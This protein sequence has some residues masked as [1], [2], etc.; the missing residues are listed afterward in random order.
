MNRSARYALTL[1][2]SASLVVAGLMPAHAVVM[3]EGNETSTP[4]PE[5]PA[6]DAG[7]PD[8]SPVEDATMAEVPVDG[9]DDAALDTLDLPVHEAHVDDHG[10]DAAPGSAPHHDDMTEGSEAE[11]GDTEGHG[12]AEGHDHA[13]EQGSTGE[14]AVLTQE[15]G[16]DG[17]DVMGVTWD[18]AD[19]PVERVLARVRADDTW[20]DWIEL[21]ISPDGPDDDTAEAGGDARPGTAPLLAADADGVQVRIE[22]TDGSQPEGARVVLIDGGT[23]G[24]GG[25]APEV[26]TTEVTD[27]PTAS[28][29]SSAS[30]A[31]TA[32]TVSPASTVQSAEVRSA[33]YRAPVSGSSDVAS[34]GMGEASVLTSTATEGR[35]PAALRPPIVTRKQWGANESIRGPLAQ[36][37]TVKA[38]VVHHTVNVNSYSRAQAPALVR[39][40]YTYHVQGR[41]WSDVGYHFLVDRFG[42]IYEGR[43]GSL[44]RV[45]LGAH[46]GGFNTDTMGVAAIGNFVDTRPP[47]AMVDS[48]AAVIAWKL[49]TYDRDPHGTARATAGSGSTHKTRRPGWTGQISVI[50]G[51]RDLA[52][53]ACPGGHL[54][55]QLP[56]IRTKVAASLAR[57][58]SS[59]ASATATYA[60]GSL[61]V[62]MRLEPGTSWTVSLRRVCSTT[63]MRSWKGT[64]SGEQR[65][66]WDLRTAGGAW[67]APGL[68][69]FRVSR[70][71]GSSTVV[72]RHWVEVLPTASSPPSQCAVERLG[73]AT[74]YETAV[75]L[76]S[77]AYPTSRNVVLVN[78]TQASIVDGLVAAPFA[79]SLDA[80]VL[81]A[82]VEG[83]PA[84]T[85]A[86]IGRLGKPKVWLVGGPGVLGPDLV[87][88]LRRMGVQ[89]ERIAGEDRFSTA[90]AV[91][92]KMG[93]PRGV[94]LASGQQ[95]SLIDAAAVSGPAAATGR[96]VLLTRTAEIPDTAMKTLKD[97]KVRNAFVV[98]GTGVVTEAV[99][100]AAH[101]AGVTTTRFGGADR[102]ATSAAVAA[103]FAKE[104][105]THDVMLASG[106][107]MSLI[108]SLAGG[109]QRKVTLL[110]DGPNVAPAVQDVARRLGIR[111][112]TMSGGPGVVPPHAVGTVATSAGIRAW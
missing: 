4:S 91:A 54:H 110:V 90:A 6:A 14:V 50:S 58:A 100:A 46:T 111:R 45:P 77:S 99:Q 85:K 39:G 78:G 82:G 57:L 74:R 27:G 16:T 38:M 26:S 49:G 29:S 52:S 65:V 13:A 42:T 5:P 55:A 69:D 83:L 30:T 23:T 68:Y 105:G 22:T 18:E 101:S 17:F 32:S 72:D 107:D 103:G 73:G 37:S 104:V 35:S 15:T 40:I 56:N 112:L 70:Q 108:D 62:A 28:S 84:V 43:Y 79:A 21:E 9:V 96:P 33:V 19:A 67:A 60:D 106:W 94:V 7:V 44:T 63:V 61:G 64:G 47:A 102:Y 109:V 88:E 75:A 98:G 8:T 76:G 25:A 81:L 34:S 51:H 20:T 36:S 3:T 11:G 41:N 92:R 2:S 89:V 10:I 86:E 95:V 12:A 71:K 66:T 93:A 48:I 24:A 53:T 80:P 1:L 31:S 97:L 87:A 59:P